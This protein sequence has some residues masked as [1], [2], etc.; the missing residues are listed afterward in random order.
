M[1]EQNNWRDG[2][3][4]EFKSAEQLKDYTDLN[5]LAKSHIEL[6]KMIGGSIRVPSEDASDEDRQKFYEKLQ[7]KVPNLAVMPDEDDA[8]ATQA[9]W[10][11]VGV[12]E[13]AAGYALPEGVDADSM[14][15]LAAMAKEAGLTKNQFS[16]LAE[17]LSGENAETDKAAREALEAQ[18][19]ELFK[20][21]GGAKD[22]K[23]TAINNMLKNSDAPDTLVQAVKDGNVGAD[24]LKWADGMIKSLGS[25]GKEISGQPKNSPTHLTP[26]EAE[27]RINEIMNN[28][29]HPYWNNASGGHAAAVKKVMD[30][31]RVVNGEKIAT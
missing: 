1:G 18:H 5:G 29:D 23:L 21:W 28:N 13:E 9:F 20:E 2:L 25:E 7:A 19:N 17:K 4:D 22:E 30:L 15:N 8:V 6:Q 11:K 16:K 24:F 14:G 31:Q 12:P 27:A 10:N 26:S 3:N